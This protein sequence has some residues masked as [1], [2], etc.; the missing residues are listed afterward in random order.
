MHA[1]VEQIMKA[2]NGGGGPS[3]GKL[4]NQRLSYMSD[5][6]GPCASPHLLLHQA[7]MPACAC[8]ACLSS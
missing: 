2:V 3:K 5:C 8:P 4:K 6:G 1:R 7:C